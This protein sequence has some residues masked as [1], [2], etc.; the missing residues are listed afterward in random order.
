M[1]SLPELKLIRDELNC[2]W[3]RLLLFKFFIINYILKIICL[4]YLL[5][6]KSL[7]YVL[8]IFENISASSSLCLIP[9][10][11]FL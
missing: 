8:I 9:I 4:L 10:S 1:K 7:N 2:D 6:N 3:K 11:A 5:L